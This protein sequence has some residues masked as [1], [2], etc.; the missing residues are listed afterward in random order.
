MNLLVLDQFSDPG[1]AQQVLM[2]LLPGMRERGW[3]ALVGVP[4][5][6]EVPVRARGL[7]FETA[8]VECGP[9]RAGRKSAADVA[10]FLVATPLLAWQVRRLAARAQADLVYVNGPRLLPAVAMARLRQPVVFHSHS[11]LPPGK[12]RA[13]AG[14]SLARAGA[15]VAASCRFVGDP[16]REYLGDRVRVIYNGIAGPGGGAW[17]PD[18]QGGTKIGCIGRISREKGQFEFLRAAGAILREIPDAR[19]LIFGAPLFGERGASRYE[20]D[21]RA[22]AAG[23]PVEFAGWIRDVYQALARLDL[24]LVPSAAN[25]AT[26]RVILE[27]FAAGVP[28][29]AFRSGGIPEV[30]ED[31]RT[32]VLVGSAEE[33]ARAAVELSRDRARAA[34]LAAAGRESWREGFRVER[35]QRELLDF[36]VERVRDHSGAAGGGG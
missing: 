5:Q 18:E 15:W 4:G 29:V 17:A 30:V 25:E 34:E 7:G 1:G 8:Q 28:V 10:R 33:M 35:F 32:G 13:L 9:Y 3:R 26:T 21:V 22:A 36:L 19:F 2:E 24:L 14:E 12:V 11:Y 16:W 6:G 23:L 20:A 31:G 27:A